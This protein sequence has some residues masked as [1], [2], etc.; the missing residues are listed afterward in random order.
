MGHVSEGPHSLR[1]RGSDASLSGTLSRSLET[2]LRTG[3][4]THLKTV[5]D[6][7]DKEDGYLFLFAAIEIEDDAAAGDFLRAIRDFEDLYEENN[8]LTYLLT[9]CVISEL[10]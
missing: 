5:P 7:P 10:Y 9:N 1:V 3:S 6:F 4:F 8:D 2:A